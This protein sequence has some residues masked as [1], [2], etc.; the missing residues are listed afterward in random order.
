MVSNL[1][2]HELNIDC[3]TEKV[4]YKPDANHISRT[5][6]KYVKNKEKEIQIYH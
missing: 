4:I 5:A 1:N 2:G 6:N 3:Y